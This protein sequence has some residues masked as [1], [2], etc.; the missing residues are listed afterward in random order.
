MDE[1]MKKLVRE[2]LTGKVL[3]YIGLESFVFR[4]LHS[5]E[6]VSPVLNSCKKYY[7]LGPAEEVGS[8]ILDHKVYFTLEAI[9][10]YG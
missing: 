5:W 2:Y 3:Y 8:W 9:I 1:I 7:T 4:E 6:E 10:K